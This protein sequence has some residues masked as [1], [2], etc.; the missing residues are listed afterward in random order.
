MG[1]EIK[2]IVTPESKLKSRKL[3]VWIVWGIILLAVIV[4]TA[5]QYTGEDLLSDVIG[6]F[7]WISALYIGGNLGSKGIH[8]YENT[9]KP[10]HETK[11][12]EVR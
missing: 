5:L 9:H 7:F 6:H 2:D 1:Q 3:M 8:A 10:K 11:A 4:F 12:P